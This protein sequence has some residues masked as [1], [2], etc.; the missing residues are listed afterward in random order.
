MRACAAHG[1]YSGGCT[2][3]SGVGRR[4]CLLRQP[5]SESDGNWKPTAFPGSMAGA[6]LCGMVCLY[7]KDL[8]LTCL[9]E[10][11]GTSVLGGLGS[12]AGLQNFLWA[13]NRQDFSFM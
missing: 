7:T 5:S 12:G 11:F 10:T 1:K 2:A 3:W 9:A 4:N 6:F 8:K 13:L